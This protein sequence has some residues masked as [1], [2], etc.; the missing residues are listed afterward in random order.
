[1]PLLD[2]VDRLPMHA[3]DLFR[4]EAKSL[5]TAVGELL[6]SDDSWITMCAIATAA[7]LKLHSLARDIANASEHAGQETAILARA[8]T[9]SLV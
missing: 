6:H 5:E 9:A 7:E 3:R 4:M 2:S 8:A 1:M